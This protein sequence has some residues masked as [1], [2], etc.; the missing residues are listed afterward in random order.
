MIPSRRE[1]DSD[2]IVVAIREPTATV[3]AKSKLD[4]LEKL[5][6]PKIRVKRITAIYVTSVVIEIA[7]SD[8]RSVVNHFSMS[9]LLV[10][11]HPIG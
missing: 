9:K 11:H 4:I 6:F 5:R 2:K 10:E 8:S 1:T 3:I 7:S